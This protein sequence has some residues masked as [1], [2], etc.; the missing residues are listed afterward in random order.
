MAFSSDKFL[1]AFIEF[2]GLMSLDYSG[3]VKQADYLDQQHPQFS[4]TI[5]L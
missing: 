5:N 4:V 2:T 3:K 1:N